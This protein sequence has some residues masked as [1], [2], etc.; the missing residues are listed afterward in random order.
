MKKIIVSVTVLCALLVIS[1]CVSSSGTKEMAVEQEG[2]A[3]FE[4]FEGDHYWMAVGNSWNDGDGSRTVKTSKQ[5]ATSGEKSL[6]CKFKFK[7]VLNKEMK[8]KAATYQTK[9]AT[10]Y[11][12]AP[13]ITDWSA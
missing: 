10:F 1:G 3:I 2:T 9:E 5:N 6:E 13:A 4:N 8:N 7:D 11:T 12:D